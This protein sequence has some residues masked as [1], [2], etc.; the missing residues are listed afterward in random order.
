VQFLDLSRL[1]NGH[2]LCST[3]TTRP[4]IFT[5]PT[6]ATNEWARALAFPVA[7]TPDQ[8][9]YHNESFHPDAFGQEAIGQCVAEIYQQPVTRDFS[10]AGAAGETPSQVTLAPIPSLPQ[11]T[12]SPL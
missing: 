11:G 5:P 4:N 10:C 1:F 3:S 2:E 7:V 9:G 6:S 8:G 12:P